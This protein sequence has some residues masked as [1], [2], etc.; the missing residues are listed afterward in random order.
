M[1][2]LSLTASAAIIAL[3]LAACGEPTEPAGDAPD[4]SQAGID[5]AGGDPAMD[6]NTSEQPDAPAEPAAQADASADS[7]PSGEVAAILAD[8]RACGAAGA[9]ADFTAEPPAEGQDAASYN[10]QVSASWLSANAERACVFTLPGG[11]QFTI[12]EAVESGPSPRSGELV[13][14]HYEGR[15]ITGEVFDS[16]YERGQPA[17]FPSDRLIPGWVEALP[18]MRVGEDWTLFIPSELGYGP[19]GTPGGPIGPNQALI[20][21]VELLGLPGRPEIDLDAL[22]ADEAGGDEG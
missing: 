20:F 8:A 21:R 11:L 10:A 12:A 9:P 13:Q 5:A 2:R 19:R 3:G 4:A 18:L 6:A 22:G 14:V 16:S 1:L 7:D 17:T 15:L